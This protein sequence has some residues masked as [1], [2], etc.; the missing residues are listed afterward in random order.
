MLSHKRDREFIK[1]VD[2][3]Y[4]YNPT[5]IRLNEELRNFDAETDRIKQGL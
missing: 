3:L 1:S 5:L 2:E 4:I